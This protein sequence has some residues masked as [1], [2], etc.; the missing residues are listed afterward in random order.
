MCPHGP[1]DEVSLAQHMEE[2]HQH[3]LPH[4]K[5]LHGHHEHDREGGAHEHGPHG[6]HSHPPTPWEDLTTG[7]L[8]LLKCCTFALNMCAV[9]A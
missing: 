9:V 2:R 5:L 3:D 7:T 6:P 4:R 1:I 8:H